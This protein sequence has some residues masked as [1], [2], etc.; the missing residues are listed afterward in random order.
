MSRI[1]YL[2]LEPPENEEVIHCP[3]IDVIPRPASDPTIVAAFR[4]FPL[5]THLIFT[6]KVGVVT[7]FALAEEETVEGK[8]VIAVGER[9]AARIEEYRVKVDYV[10]ERETAEGVVDVLLGLSLDDAYCFWPHSALSR[11]VI[12]SFFEGEGYLFRECVLYDTVPRKGVELPDLAMI[13]EIV[14]TSPSTV[15]AFRQLVGALPQ[16]KKL[17]GIGPVTTRALAES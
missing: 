10:A 2:G 13:D 4:D 11:R 17:V 7:F 1:L 14:F 15:E 6:S 9:T 5:Y 3:I 12:P 16:D 8:Q